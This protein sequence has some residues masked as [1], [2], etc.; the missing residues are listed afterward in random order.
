MVP[1]P[2]SLDAAGGVDVVL[3]SFKCVCASAIAVVLIPCDEL[4]TNNTVLAA[5]TPPPLKCVRACVCVW[6]CYSVVQMCVC[7][8][9]VSSGVVIVLYSVCIHHHHHH[10]HNTVHPLS[11]PLLMIGC[12]CGV[13]SG[14]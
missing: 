14:E 4:S 5:S 3:Y 1:P 13:L 9:R 11:T 10:Y 12:A 2:L 6:C 7:C 8:L